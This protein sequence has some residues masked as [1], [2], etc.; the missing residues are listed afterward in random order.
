MSDA[1]QH[2]ASG[3]NRA[4]QATL[5]T[6]HKSRTPY[7]NPHS[8]AMANPGKVTYER[9]NWKAFG[10]SK[11]VQ[12]KEAWTQYKAHSSTDVPL[13]LGNI[14]DRTF[15][16]ARSDPTNRRENRVLNSNR[17][18]MPV[19]DATML[20]AFHKR[21]HVVVSHSQNASGSLYDTRHGRDHP[22][23]TGREV[24]QSA[25]VGYDTSAPTLQAPLSNSATRQLPSGNRLDAP[26]PAR[27]RSLTLDNLRSVP[28]LEDTSKKT[29]LQQLEQ[30]L[31][32]PPAPP[33]PPAPPVQ[34]PRR[35]GGG[36][37]RGGRGGGGYRGGRGRGGGGQTRF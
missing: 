35:G 5:Q 15:Q 17:Y 4:S 22:K 1:E 21:R 9:T 24:L 6:M 7:E 29:T 2:Q 25:A 36:G 37:G 20:A 32:T 30:S 23:I 13:H 12:F 16:Q 26:S 31:V 18:S 11:E 34:Q 33:A 28:G 19:N 27:T 10:R 14:G 8:F 3:I